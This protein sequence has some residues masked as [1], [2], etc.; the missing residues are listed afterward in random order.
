[1][2]K[3]TVL[4]MVALSLGMLA[5]FDAETRF[6][7]R[8]ERGVGKTGRGLELLSH[9]ESTSRPGQNGLQRRRQHALG[10]VETHP[11]PLLVLGPPQFRRHRQEDVH[12]RGFGKVVTRH[13]AAAIGRGLAARLAQ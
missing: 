4:Q 9:L 13:L 3:P 8:A 11:A 12:L 1:M 6:R 10:V 2:R 7:L 5:E